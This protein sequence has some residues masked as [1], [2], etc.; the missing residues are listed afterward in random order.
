MIGK[1]VRLRDIIVPIAATPSAS[2]AP[3]LSTNLAASTI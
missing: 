2:K 3:L 1:T